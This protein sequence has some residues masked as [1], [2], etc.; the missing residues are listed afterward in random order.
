MEICSSLKDIS[1]YYVL[2]FKTCNMKKPKHTQKVH[3]LTTHDKS[4]F[5]FHIFLLL[6]SPPM[7]K[8]S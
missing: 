8:S 6:P 3:Q 1:N 7:T 2:T 5:I 4:C